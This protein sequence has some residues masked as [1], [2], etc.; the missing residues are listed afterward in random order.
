MAG[1]IA[2]SDDA[3]MFINKDQAA[4]SEADSDDQRKRLS[5]ELRK[6]FDQYLNNVNTNN[7]ASGS[8]VA[9][10]T[11]QDF[12]SQHNVEFETISNST[13]RN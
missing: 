6:A 8:G 4:L 2:A 3:S 10:A 5:N 7:N 11:S 1:S 12:A 9:D 13:T